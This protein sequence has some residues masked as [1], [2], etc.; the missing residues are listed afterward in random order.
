MCRLA[1]ECRMHSSVGCTV[2]V[3]TGRRVELLCNV[4]LTVL[5]MT[6]VKGM[7]LLD[8]RCALVVGGP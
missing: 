8:W 1:D 6:T 5:A 3:T 7:A 2:G 4:A